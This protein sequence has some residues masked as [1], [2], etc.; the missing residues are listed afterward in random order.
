[1]SMCDRLGR[2]LYELRP[3]LMPYRRFTRLE[4]ELWSLHLKEKESRHGKQ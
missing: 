3:D 4:A 2:P 1:M